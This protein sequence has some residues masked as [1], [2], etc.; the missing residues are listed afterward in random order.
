[1]NPYD[2]HEARRIL[3]AAADTA[4][5][6]KAERSRRFLELTNAGVKHSHLWPTVD[7]E[8]A[9]LAAEAAHAEVE[10]KILWLLATD[11]RPRATPVDAFDELTNGETRE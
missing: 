5:A 4:N 6:L 10:A 1:M 2:E 7:I 11:T 3:T 9:D 8:T